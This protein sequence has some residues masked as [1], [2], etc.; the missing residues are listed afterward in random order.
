MG[1]SKGSQICAKCM[2]QFYWLVANKHKKKKKKFT[3]LVS[4]RIA[5]MNIKQNMSKY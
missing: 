3:F 5:E 1:Y 4:A 2:L